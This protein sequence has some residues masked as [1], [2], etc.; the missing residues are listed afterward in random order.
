MERGWGSS[1]Q[2]PA[3]VARQRRV[4]ESGTTKLCGPVSVQVPDQSSDCAGPAGFKTAATAGTR[5]WGKGV[6]R[7]PVAKA[8]PVLVSSKD[9][10]EAGKDAAMTDEAG[11]EDSAPDL[12]AHPRSASGLQAHSGEQSIPG[13]ERASPDVPQHVHGLVGYVLNRMSVLLLLF[14]QRHLVGIQSS[15]TL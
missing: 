15:A 6:W 3:S 5:Q 11:R 14:P 12:T 1:S 8:P 7:V 9:W 10:G 2:A 13:A 4:G